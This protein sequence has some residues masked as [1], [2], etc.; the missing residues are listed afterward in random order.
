MP[1]GR[2]LEQ[3][4]QIAIGINAL[5]LG[6]HFLFKS[7]EHPFLEAWQVSIQ[8]VVVPIKLFRIPDQQRL[9]VFSKTTEQ[10]AQ[11][12]RAKDVSVFVREWSENIKRFR[13]LV[14]N[15]FQPVDVAFHKINHVDNAAATPARPGSIKQR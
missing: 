10:R 15:L 7:R 4:E 2:G 3:L 6:A 8:P 13:S 1:F 5:G 11:V 14:R 12:V 9:L